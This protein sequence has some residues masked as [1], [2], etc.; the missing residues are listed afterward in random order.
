L[1][2]YVLRPK[3]A[4]SGYEYAIVLPENDAKHP[5]VIAVEVKGTMVFIDLDIEDVARIAGASHAG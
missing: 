3:T 5:A 2:D 4:P 1:T